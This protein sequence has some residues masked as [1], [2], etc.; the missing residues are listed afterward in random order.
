[1][2][3]HTFCTDNIPSSL[4][5]QHSECCKKLNIEIEYHY[6]SHENN[7]LRIYEQHGE[8]MTL[9]MKYSSEDVVCFLDLDCI[10]HDRDVL[11]KSYDWVKQNKSF[12]GNAQNVS[13]TKM[14]NHVYAGASTLMIH[15]EC[16]EHLGSPSMSCVFENDLTQIDTAQLLT[17]RADQCGFPYRLFYPIGYDGPEEYELSGYG[18]YGR[19]TLYPA[20]YHFF[21]LTECLDNIPNLWTNRVEN[22]LNNQKIIPNY[23][24]SF[25]GL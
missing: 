1:M 25:Y 14:R 2:K 9:L 20:T 5:N 4:I 19:G 16:W 24:S 13:H 17:L 7:F 11:Q 18:K 8:F 22:I 12:C 23:Y 3:F 21:A 10:P 15:K 6:V